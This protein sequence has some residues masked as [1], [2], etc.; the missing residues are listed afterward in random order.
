MVEASNSSSWPAGGTALF[1]DVTSTGFVPVTTEILDEITHRIV[2]ALHPQRILLFGSY[3]Y[4]QPTPD[5]DVDLL[6]ILETDQKPADRQVAVSR[7]IRPRPF[8]VDI[9]ARTPEEM[10][11]ALHRQDP[12]IRDILDRGRVLYG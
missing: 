6:V 12:F 3:A 4:S 2:T 7:L 10:E 1:P 5:S 9:L 8:P 11:E